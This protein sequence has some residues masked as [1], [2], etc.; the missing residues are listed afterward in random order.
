MRN[1][2]GDTPEIAASFDVAHRETLP[3]YLRVVNAKQSH[4]KCSNPKCRA[5]VPVTVADGLKRL[6]LL[7]WGRLVELPALSDRAM[8]SVHERRQAQLEREVEALKNEQDDQRRA[9]EDDIAKREAETTQRK[10]QIARLEQDVSELKSQANRLRDELSAKVE[11]ARDDLVKT[12]LRV[13][14]AVDSAL[15]HAQG[16][17]AADSGYVDGIRMLRRSVDSILKSA[18]YEA[19]EVVGAMFDAQLHHSVSTVETDE[20]DVDHIVEEVQRGYVNSRSGEVVR[21]AMVSVAIA[22]SEAEDDAAEADARDAEDDA[23]IDEGDEPLEEVNP[24]DGAEDDIGSAAAE[25]AE[26]DDGAATEDDD[27]PAKETP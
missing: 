6:D 14:D 16:Q 24:N 8:Q 1:T 12:L 23:T 9:H 20:Y 21:H 11:V 4:I 19:Q 17:R 18:G 26:P 25:N 27:E 5:S 2:N 3:T 7:E 22:P 13:P 15:K 10:R